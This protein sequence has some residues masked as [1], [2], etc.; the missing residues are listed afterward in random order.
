[1][2]VARA[3]VRRITYTSNTA[4]DSNLYPMELIIKRQTD[5]RLAEAND[6]RL[7]RA[8]PADND[9][10]RRPSWTARA[11]NR[12]GD[13][14]VSAGETLRSSPDELHAAHSHRAAH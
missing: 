12:L 8:S 3:R 5:E 14:L 2:I 6:N 9:E 10:R 11:R 1:V 13:T 7:F 4:E